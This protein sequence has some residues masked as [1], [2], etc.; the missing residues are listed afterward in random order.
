[1]PV[2]PSISV[3][4]R[5]AM[6]ASDKTEPTG[7]DYPHG[8]GTPEAMLLR[9]KN[10]LPVADVNWLETMM[11]LSWPHPMPPQDDADILWHFAR[12]FMT[13]RDSLLPRGEVKTAGD[14]GNFLT[15]QLNRIVSLEQLHKEWKNESLEVCN[16]HRS[17]RAPVGTLEE[18]IQVNAGRRRGREARAISI[19]GALIDAWRNQITGG[20][21]LLCSGPGLY[22]DLRILRE[23]RV[24]ADESET[25]EAILEGRME[26][27]FD[28]A[29]RGYL[30]PSFEKTADSEPGDT[31]F[32]QGVASSTK[33]SSGGIIN[34]DDY[35]PEDAVMS[36]VE[37][38][39]QRWQSG[40]QKCEE[41]AASVSTPPPLVP[42]DRAR[43]PAFVTRPDT[44]PAKILKTCRDIK[45]NKIAQDANAAGIEFINEVDD[46]EVPPGIGI[47]FP[48]LER[49]YL[50]IELRSSDIGIEEV[51]PLVGCKCDGMRGVKTKCSCQAGPKPAYTA[52]AQNHSLLVFIALDGAS[53]LPSVSIVWPNIRGNYQFRSS[54]RRSGNGA[55]GC[56]SI[57]RREEANKLSDNRASHCF[58]LDVNEDPDEEPPKNAY[59]VD[60]YA[61]VL[62]SS[63]NWTRF[64][65]YLTK[66]FLVKFLD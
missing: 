62:K 12:S 31:A 16:A 10:A 34:V 58:D 27:V 37:L 26:R 64:I 40:R 46:E 50:F 19:L 52:E 59:S 20:W 21:T 43:P 5:A 51:S 66:I 36:P 41:G 56:L 11:I 29:G 2:D 18:A 49:K 23:C 6:I 39:P 14:S 63:G 13:W 47:L 57:C 22:S 48:Y 33:E 55:S 44:L 30:W 32:P 61:C 60:A 42:F 8:D 9:L 53:A 38:P 3:G 28:S 45:W 35:H 54:K 25:V 17:E 15:Q 65:K 4:P 1:M 24:V 7:L